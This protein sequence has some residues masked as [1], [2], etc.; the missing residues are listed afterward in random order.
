MGLISDNWGGTCVEWWSSPDAL[1]KCNITTEEDSVGAGIQNSQLWNAMIVPYLDMRLRG[2]NTF[3][4]I[5][6]CTPYL[7][8][9][10][11]QLLFLPPKLFF[12]TNSH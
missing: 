12:L 10:N 8:T 4:N 3:E 7:P 9:K 6:F 5:C 1:K 2:K 11:M